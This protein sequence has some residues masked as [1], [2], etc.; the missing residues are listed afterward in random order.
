MSATKTERMNRPVTFYFVRHAQ[1]LHEPDTPDSPLSGLGLVQARKTAMRLALE[2]FD[3][4]YISS[5]RRA[6]QTADEILAVHSGVRR[7]ITDDIQEVSRFHF[8]PDSSAPPD[9]FRA[10]L[11]AERDTMQRFV[12]RLRHA[13]KPGESALLVCHGN[14]IRTLIPLLCN[15]VPSESVLLEVFNA[16]ISILDLLASGTGVLRLANSVEHLAPDEITESAAI[17]T[18]KPDRDQ[19]ASGGDEIPSLWMR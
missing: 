1:A 15:R 11:E 13:H 12:N 3:Y 17:R 7:V 9:R 10:V 14:T 6:R 16:S 2:P 18:R 8:C 19:T 4:C 5:L